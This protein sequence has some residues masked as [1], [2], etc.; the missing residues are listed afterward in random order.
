MEDVIRKELLNRLE[1]YHGEDIEWYEDNNDIEDIKSAL[2]ELG[3]EDFVNWV[4]SNRKP[5]KTFEQHSGTGKKFLDEIKELEDFL[6]LTINGSILNKYTKEEV[7]QKMSHALKQLG[8][9]KDY[10]HHL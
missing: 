5:I 7:E 4:I 9:L 10:F 2:I 8:K 6:L 1:D 3:D